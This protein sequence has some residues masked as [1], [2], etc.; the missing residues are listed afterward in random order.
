M[1]VCIMYKVV[2]LTCKPGLCSK[3]V[4]QQMNGSSVSMYTG[5]AT[6][7]LV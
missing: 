2:R 7:H 4:G 6:E 5:I 1:R 3:R